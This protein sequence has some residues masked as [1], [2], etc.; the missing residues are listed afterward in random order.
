MR[1]HSLRTTPVVSF[2]MLLAVPLLAQ[3]QFA[4]FTGTIISR[5]GNPLA[6]V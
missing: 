4:S 1:T 6:D 2:V 3:T 5:D